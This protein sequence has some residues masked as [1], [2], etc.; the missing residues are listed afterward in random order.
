MSVTLIYAGNTVRAT[1]TFTPASGT[2]ALADVT[3]RAY[4]H[5][6]R[7]T[8]NL[9]VAE[10]AANTFRA[11]L[12]IPDATGPGRWTV[13]FESNAPSPKIALEDSTTT[14]TVVASILT[15]P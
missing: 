5:A 3:A 15:T 14:F 12:A 13:R 2:V 7:A 1:C 8:T 11:D 4:E 9:T 10:T 6:T